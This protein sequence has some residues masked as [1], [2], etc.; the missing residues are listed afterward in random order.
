MRVRGREELINLINRALDIQG[1]L[2][3]VEPIVSDVR[4]RGDAAVI[5]YTRRFDGVSLSRLSV[6]HEELGRISEGVDEEVRHHI[7]QAMDSVRTLYELMKPPNV[8]HVYN[9]VERS[10][11]WIPIR[12]VG[13]Y[14]P[15]GYFSTLIMTGV[16]ARV[17]GVEELVVTT[18][19]NKDG[20]ISPEVAY[21][22]FKLNARVYRVG[23]P[24]A[25]AAMAFGTESV[26]RVDKIVGPGNL[27]VQ[28]AKL[29]VSP[30]VGIDGFEGPTE[31]VVCTS[32]GQNPGMVAL[33]LAAQLEHS[34]AVGVVMTWDEDYLRKVEE[35]IDGLTNAPYFSILVSGP[36]ECV[37]LINELS[38]EHASL[39][40]LGDYVG[41]VRNAG[42]ISVDT[43]SALID[44]VAGPS[45]VLPTSGSARWRG[46][47]TVLDF[48]KPL[49]TVRV[50]SGESSRGMFMTGHK[51]ALR[52]GFRIHAK[53]LL[54]TE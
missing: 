21:V 13:I 6:D 44:Y 16:I 34:G 48:M 22:A 52:E 42:A 3:S 51:L 9:G 5:E 40:G 14:V 2:R 7:D 19:P 54:P 27:Y 47:L 15:R 39:W 24:M 28:A 4:A 45:H 37:E 32:P 20:G 53:S 23:G 50:V 1:F 35:E 18:P 33:D 36:R 10:V 11:R 41:Y 12:S 29:V 17:A 31:L 8:V 25:I 30:F 46:T 43:P 26:P 49:A 38:P